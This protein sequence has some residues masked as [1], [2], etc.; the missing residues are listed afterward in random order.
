MSIAV[1]P[2]CS[3]CSSPWGLVCANIGKP[4]QRACQCRTGN[5]WTCSVPSAVG[6]SRGRSNSGK[7]PCHRWLCTWIRMILQPSDSSS[8]RRSLRTWRSVASRW[9]V[10][11]ASAPNPRLHPEV[12]SSIAH[13]CLE[14]SQHI[15]LVDGGVLF[16]CLHSSLRA[17]RQPHLPD[18]A[19][20]CC[21]LTHRTLGYPYQN[22]MHHLFCSLRI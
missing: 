17:S 14:R 21:Y 7:G 1:F 20:S 9:V 8:D 2:T 18:T 19:Q 10:R 16:C 5:R 4:V 13:Q 15:L 22:W 11:E 3:E 12:L 6:T